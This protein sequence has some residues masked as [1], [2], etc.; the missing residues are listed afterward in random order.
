MLDSVEAEPPEEEE[1]EEEPDPVELPLEEEPEAVPLEDELPE[2]DPLELLP[3]LEEEPPLF[4]EPDSEPEELL[5]PFELL[6]S[7]ELAE[8]ELDELFEEEAFSF[9]LVLAV[10]DSLEDFSV[11]ALF[12]DAASCFVCAVSVAV[13]IGSVFSPIPWP[14]VN[15]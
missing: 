8:S 14:A 7:E 13:K 15:T 6:E 10:E 4:E 12:S 11:L 1:L 3:E 5:L 9:T 2:F